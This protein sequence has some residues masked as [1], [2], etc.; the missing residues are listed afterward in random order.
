MDLLVGICPQVPIVC[1]GGCISVLC[2]LQFTALVLVLAIAGVQTIPTD[3]STTSAKPTVDTGQCNPMQH[4]EYGPVV[5]IG[6]SSS[7]I[8]CSD[9]GLS[10]FDTFPPPACSY[11]GYPLVWGP[12]N[13]VDSA[14]ECCRACQNYLPGADGKK[15][16]GRAKALT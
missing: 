12:T 7:A 3:A 9:I 1:S 11:T 6:F 10:D 14:E 2:H 16:N 4:A 8:V 13:R 15:C 5:F